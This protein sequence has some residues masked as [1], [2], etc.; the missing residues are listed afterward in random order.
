MLYNYVVTVKNSIFEGNI[1]SFIVFET[2]V[3]VFT[4]C[5]FSQNSQLYGY[6]YVKKVDEI[7]FES[8]LFDGNSASLSGGSIYISCVKKV[9]ITSSNFQNNFAASGGS[10][11]FDINVI[12]VEISDCVFVNNN[13]TNYGGSIMI[14]QN[15]QNINISNSIFTGNIASNGDGGAIGVVRI[16]FLVLIFFKINYLFFFYLICLFLRILKTMHQKKGEPFT[17]NPTIIIHQFSALLSPTILLITVLV[18]Q[19]LFMRVIKVL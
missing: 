1:G 16:I 7:I 17:L 18:A 9:V 15:N 4:N 11:C 8:C 5:T 10:I 6:L 14:N 2:E 3:A 13:A 12:E 19:Y